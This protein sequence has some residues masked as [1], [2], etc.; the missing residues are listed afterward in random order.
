MSVVPYDILLDFAHPDNHIIEHFFHDG[1]LLRVYHL[2]IGVFEFSVGLKISQVESSVVLEP[3]IVSSFV[4]D[5]HEIMLT[6]FSFLF[7]SNG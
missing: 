4:I 6:P 5:L 1:T 7:S 3:F 2:V